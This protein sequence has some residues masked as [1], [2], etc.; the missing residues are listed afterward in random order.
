MSNYAIRVEDLGKQYHIGEYQGRYKSLRDS[1]A[2]MAKAPYQ[3]IRNRMQANHK[4]GNTIW[5]LKDVSFEVQHGEVVG[6]IGRNGAGK[7][8]LLKVLARITE[9][10]TGEVRVR[11]RVGSLLE[12]GTGFHPELTGR[13][14]LFLNGAILGMSRKEIQSKFDEIVD[15]SEIERFID[16]PAKYY[17]S[18]MYMRLAFSVAAHLEPE[19]LLVDE[20]LAV[21]D[22]QFQKKCMGKMGE[23]ANQGRTVLF[24]SHN[25]GAIKSLTKRCI[26]IDRGM[27]LNY[28]QTPLVIKSYLEQSTDPGLL[29]NESI[30]YYR[31]KTKQSS[32]VKI[33][34]IYLEKEARNLAMM[35]DLCILIRFDATRA[36]QGANITLVIKNGRGERVALIYSWDQHFSLSMEKG[37]CIVK[38]RVRGIN[39]TPDKYYVDVGINQSVYTLAYDVILDYPLFTV[40]LCEAV[41][42]WPDRPWGAIHI[43]DAEWNIEANQS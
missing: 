29:K 9:P 19:I 26:Q 12:V 13:E 5:A 4:E 27:M 21:G 7:S 11:G 1:L 25:M 18:G 36:I 42:Y 31:R 10:T 24:V 28:D 43:R 32:T 37:E 20:V 35:N 14:N 6:I 8:T 38:V 33:K 22:L 2:R 16:T 40:D 3:A 15:F 30:E 41:E 23:V 39:L 17:S 34:Q